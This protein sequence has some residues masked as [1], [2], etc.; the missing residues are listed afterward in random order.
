MEQTLINIA[1]LVAASL[2]IFGMKRLQS[3]ATA[4][5]GNRLSSM[6]MLI[7]VVATLFVANILT[8]VEML[9]GVVVGG[10]SERYW[11]GVLS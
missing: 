4:R 10:G 9:A 7:A 8:P 2:F 1:Y 5:Q 11:P 3:P 6:A